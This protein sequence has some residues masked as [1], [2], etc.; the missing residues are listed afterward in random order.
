MKVTNKK[1]IAFLVDSDCMSENSITSLV[2]DFKQMVVKTYN[3]GTCTGTYRINSE[4]IN[5]IEQ[6]LNK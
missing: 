4:R 3:G 6:Y 5:K 1:T 2:Y